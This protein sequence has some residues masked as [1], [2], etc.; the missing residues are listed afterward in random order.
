M[1]RRREERADKHTQ[2]FNEWQHL[3]AFVN[4]TQHR[5]I[6]Q[7]ASA[8]HLE[9]SEKVTEKHIPSLASRIAF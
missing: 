8:R 6:E 7:I 3:L 4:N 1:S 9:M 2:R 5:R